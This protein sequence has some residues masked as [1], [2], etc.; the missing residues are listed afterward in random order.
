M[1]DNQ[2]SGCG[3][4][5]C[6]ST[7]FTIYLIIKLILGA[8]KAASADIGEFAGAAVWIN[9]AA[10]AGISIA[11]VA[12]IY[13]AIQG[14]RNIKIKGR[15]SQLTFTEQDKYNDFPA[16]IDAVMG[17]LDYGKWGFE[18]IHAGALFDFSS[19][20]VFQSEFCKVRVWT[21]RDR[22]YEQS[23]IYYSYGRLHAPNEKHTIRLEKWGGRE[24]HC[25]HDHLNLYLVLCFLDEVSP[26]EL[27]RKPFP[28]LP[29]IL[30]KF[31]KEASGWSHH[32]R[33]ARQQNVIWNHYGQRLFELYDYRK[34]NVW[35]KYVGFV[36]E[37]RFLTEKKTPPSDYDG[38]PFSESRYPTTFFY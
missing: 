34:P 37:L 11:S 18:I 20:I 4:L 9:V 24:Y 31:E 8:T 17:H 3:S 33:F 22:P 6:L 25:W 38:D 36:K 23:E 32:E 12:L 29:D 30:S 7:P 13:A 2:K 27:V 5:G 26:Q 16:L 14:Y 15:S 28:Y 21:F 1:E 10:L 19:A 35:N